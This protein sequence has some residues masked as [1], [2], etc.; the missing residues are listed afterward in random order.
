MINFFNKYSLASCVLFCLFL[1]T[2]NSVQ[3]QQD[4]QFTHNMF[5]GLVYNPAVAGSKETISTFLLSRNQWV[6][7]DGAPVTQTLSINA[8]VAS[9]KSGVGL[10]I[11]NDKLGF[12]SQIGATASFAYKLKLNNNSKLAFGLSVGFS[13]KTIDGTQFSA[14]NSSDTKIPVNRISDEVFPDVGFGV[15]YQSTKTYI[16]YSASHLTQPRVG[17]KSG[18]LPET[19]IR[20]VRH[21]FITSGYNYSLSSAIDIRPSV[22]LKLTELAPTR[23]VFDINGMV[24]YKQKVWG[25]MSYRSIDAVAFLVGFNINEQ[26]RV[27]Y[28]YDLNTSQLANFNSGSHEIVIGYDWKITNVPRNSLIIKTPRFL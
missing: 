7:F 21:H 6:G 28:S 18:V 16:A 26:L 17:L 14:I 24:F 27:G 19:G 5:N 13:Q 25:G 4:V 3:A 8:P 1:T 23:P 12:E 9:L 11:V 20:L 15:L 2:R 10:H 22:F